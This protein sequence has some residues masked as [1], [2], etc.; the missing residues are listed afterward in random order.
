[1]ASVLAYTLTRGSRSITPHGIRGFL[2]HGYHAFASRV[3]SIWWA[4]VGGPGP[5]PTGSKS[6]LFSSS[7]STFTYATF[8]LYPL[9]RSD[10]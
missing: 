5:Q 3:W 4:V 1:M 10:L 6:S 7:V 8:S 2:L 9:L